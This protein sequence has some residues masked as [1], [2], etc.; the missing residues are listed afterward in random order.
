MI[1][2]SQPIELFKHPLLPLEFDSQCAVILTSYP[3]DMLMTLI[4]P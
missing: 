4:Y 2:Q 1:V 3:V